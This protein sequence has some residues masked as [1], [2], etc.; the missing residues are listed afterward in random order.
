M[1]EVKLREGKI[2]TL[3]LK[4]QGYNNERCL[5]ETMQAIYMH[6]QKEI[7]HGGD[8]HHLT[9]LAPEPLN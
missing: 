7:F 4:N 9:P 1:Q 3:K 6:T 8:W 5:D 2:E